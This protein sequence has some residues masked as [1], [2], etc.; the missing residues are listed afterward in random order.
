MQTS[1]LF[2]ALWIETMG[3]SHRSEHD[4]DWE[5]CHHHEGDN[6]PVINE[7]PLP[8]FVSAQGDA[9][10]MNARQPLPNDGPDGFTFA[11][12]RSE[13]LHPALHDQSSGRILL[14]DC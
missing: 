14:T 1:D 8:H 4:M 5:V 3:Q 2:Q 6:E 7:M 12:T 10:K 11:P 13:H 9:F